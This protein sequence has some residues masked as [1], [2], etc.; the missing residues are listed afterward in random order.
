MENTQNK[1]IKIAIIDYSA[2]N[3]HSVYKAFAKKGVSIEI[4]NKETEL[5]VFDAIV[6]PGVG[7]CGSAMD[8]LTKVGLTRRLNYYVL[9]LKKPV[10]G[11]CLGFQIMT[12]FSEEGKVKGLGWIP[13]N[14]CHIRNVVKSPIR[15]PHIGWND[16][17]VYREGM[18]L[19]SGMIENPNFYF[20]H[21]YFVPFKEIDGNLGITEYGTS[22][23]S[24][25]QSKNIYGTQFH[26]EKS[27]IGGAVLIQ[28]FLNEVLNAKS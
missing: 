28:N 13:V 18:S 27:Y 6:L 23:I 3:I 19:L 16:V 17:R 2:G 14:V 24:L 5:D 25:Y 7:A 20:A 9:E 10:L 12:E 8:F 11:I 4:V 21:S 1:K 22:F 15:V 26:P